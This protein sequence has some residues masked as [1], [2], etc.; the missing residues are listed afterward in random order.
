MNFLVIPAIDLRGGR[1]VRLFQG[2]YDRETVYGDDPVAM[3]R[4]W[5][6]EGAR[7]LHVVDL[8]GAREGRPAQL[9]VVR[10]IVEALEIPV[11]LGGGL[12]DAAA[13][14][15]ALDAGVERAII[16]TAA[17][18]TEIARPLF[19]EFRERLAV[20]LDARAG[21]VA[22]RGWR[23]DSGRDAI[24]LARE[25]AALGARRFIFTDIATDGT[26]A[27]P[28]VDAT[29]AL[30]QAVDVPVIASG[31]VGSIDDLRALAALAECGV[32]G[33]IVGKALYVGSVHLRE[34]VSPP[35]PFH[36]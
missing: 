33:V 3:A 31:G 8:D 19:E 4:R 26:L 15:A 16:G 29:R 30:A 5:E 21:R 10:R 20:G 23:E 13:V 2:D 24:E 12:R 32:E 7:R 9:E 11:Q 17:V 18:D 36:S 28:A 14:R 6:A 25:L 27:G 34:A 35:H 1:C 22:V